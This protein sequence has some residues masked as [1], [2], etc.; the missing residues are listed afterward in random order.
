MPLAA[1]VLLS[2]N[3]SKMGAGENPRF[4]LLRWCAGVKANWTVP[5]TQSWPVRGQ[6]A[7]TSARNNETNSS[8]IMLSLSIPKP[9]A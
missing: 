8:Y 9:A 1:T 5:E 6:S 2:G 4:A 7:G 3:S